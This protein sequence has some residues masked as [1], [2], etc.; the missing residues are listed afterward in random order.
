MP[1]SGAV[2]LDV[3]LDDPSLRDQLAQQ[4][5]GAS[6]VTIERLLDEAL[7]VAL[8][9]GRDGMNYADVQQARLRTELGLTNPVDYTARERTVVATHEAGHAVVA[10]L[11][12]SRRPE[13]LSIIKR[14]SSLGLLAHGDLDEVPAGFSSSLA[15]LAGDRD[16]AWL[17]LGEQVAKRVQLGER[18][19]QLGRLASRCIVARGTTGHV[20]HEPQRLLGCP[21]HV[22]LPV[23]S[24]LSTER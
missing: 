5:L 11:T 10:H 12:G 13:V 22:N 9:A 15:V 18:R 24:W 2:S 16:E 21:R 6:P 20:E 1:S 3:E 14:G 4:T 23:T 7:I 17:Q 19:E 8:R